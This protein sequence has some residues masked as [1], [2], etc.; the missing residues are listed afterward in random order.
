MSKK[1]KLILSASRVKTYQQCP[2]RYYYSYLEKLP[3]KDWP[4]FDLG[5]LAHGVL[6]HFHETIRSDADDKSGLKKLMKN[7]FQK[8]RASMEK[9]KTISPEILLEARDLLKEYL[10]SLESK[11]IGSKILSL[12]ESFNLPLND[13]FNIRGFVDR[14]DLDSDGIYHIKDYKTNKNKRYMEPFQLQTYGIFLLDKFPDIDYFRGSYIMLRFGGEH[15]SYEFNRE[16]VDKIRTNL[17]EY[18]DRI[19]K[20][21]RWITKT[22]KLCDWCDFKE[23]CL[24]AW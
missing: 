11:G 17:I 18:G 19:T 20:E 1:T 2:R 3:K 22:T 10:D 4:H 9:N 23:P 14:L 8:Q 16:D 15:I 13:D 24:N 12:E 7:A 21:E 6:E 5:T